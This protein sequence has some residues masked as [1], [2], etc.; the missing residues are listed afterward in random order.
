[1]ILSKQL[2]IIVKTNASLSSHALMFLALVAS[3]G[4][5]PIVICH[6]VG[7]INLTFY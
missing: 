6:V 2:L 5:I 1:M 7:A 4:G 3:K